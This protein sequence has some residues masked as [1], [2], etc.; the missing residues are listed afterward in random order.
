MSIVHTNCEHSLHVE[1]IG[2]SLQGIRSGVR[3]IRHDPELVKTVVRELQKLASELCQPK[4]PHPAD[5]NQTDV[6]R[7]LLADSNVALSVNELAELTGFPPNGV[8]AILYTNHRLFE[9]RK[10]SPRHVVWSLKS[11]SK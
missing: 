8:R 3:G 7:D 10:L 4:R 2:T 5:M 1:L 6:I 11:D 9:P